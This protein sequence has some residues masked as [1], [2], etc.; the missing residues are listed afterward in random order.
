[1]L[2]FN[3]LCMTIEKPVFEPE[4][5]HIIQVGPRLAMKRRHVLCGGVNVILTS[6]DSVNMIYHVSDRLQ[7]IELIDISRDSVLPC[8]NSTA[9]AYVPII[10]DQRGTSL[11][12]LVV[13]NVRLVRGLRLSHEGK[14]AGIELGT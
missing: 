12:R 3:T 4:Y 11:S 10:T 6:K 1:M 14:M 5:R 2:Y 9:T 8:R 13:T 7:S